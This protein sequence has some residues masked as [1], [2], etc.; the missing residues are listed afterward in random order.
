[1]G[2]EPNARRDS[3]LV[4]ASEIEEMEDVL[5]PSPSHFEKLYLQPEQAVAGKLRLTFA[6]PTPIA[7]VGF[8]LANTPAT[9]DLMGWHGAGADVGNADAGTGSYF[10]F[11]AILLY[12]GGMG[13]WILGNT[14]PAVIFLYVF[15]HNSV[16]L[17]L[18]MRT[19]SSF[20]GFWGTFGATLTPFFNAIKGYGNDVAGFYDS[21]AMFL[22]FMAVL[23]FFYMIAALRTNLCLVLVLL[24]FTVTFPCLAA[25]Y[26]YAASGVGPSTSCRV[27]GGAFAFIA[28]LI[29]WYLVRD[30]PTLTSKKDG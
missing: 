23:C 8:L 22:I 30:S 26:F 5:K 12:V 9:I 11:A 6:N 19:V 1:M 18:L 3:T 14:F 4:K 2:P 27:V 16:C 17:Y 7:L 10:F 13:E 20:G 25:S 15:R 21:F 29:A 24:C 28:S